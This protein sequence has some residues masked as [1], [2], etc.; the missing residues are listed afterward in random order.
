MESELNEWID[1]Q[2][3][4]VDGD[5]GVDESDYMQWFWKI[6]RKVVGRPISLSSEFQRTISGLRE[7]AY[8]ADS[9]STKGLDGQQ[10]ESI[11]RIRFIAQDCL[12]D[13][14][15]CPATPSAPPQI[16]L[17]K[18]SRGK[19]RIRRKG[20][21]KRRRKG[22]QMEYQEAS[23]D[24]QPQFY[25][26]VIEA[27]QLH[28]HQEDGEVGQLLICQ[29]ADNFDPQQLCHGAGE[30]D[31]EELLNVVNKED[32]A[33]L[34]NATKDIID[35]QSC[36]DSDNVNDSQP[37]HATVEV[38]DRKIYG[39]A[40]RSDHD[41]QLHDASEKLPDTN[42]R[43][44]D[45]LLPYTIQEKNDPHPPDAIEEIIDLHLPDATKEANDLQLPDT[46]EEAN[47]FQLPDTKDEVSDSTLLD[48]GEKIDQPKAKASIEDVPASLD[49]V[50]DVAK[51]GDTSVGA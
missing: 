30:G 9:F 51:Q 44:K 10:F 2:L 16:E 4:I 50:E 34:S 38:N 17:G 36:K 3:H 39:E 8:L 45:F 46:I 48:A 14:I 20:I 41:S 42:E 5:D 6:T 12:R 15:E 28:L 22:D 32:G 11:S 49:T 29:A 35:S 43:L 27:D 24:D 7:I 25:G 13:Q 47:D 37:C 26:A 33:K 40:T 23:E 1:R 18:R 21:G 19:E 31:S